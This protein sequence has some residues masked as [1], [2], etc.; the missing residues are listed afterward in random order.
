M[1]G[2]FMYSLKVVP[3]RTYEE[4]GAHT[5]IYINEINQLQIQRD[6]SIKILCF[7]CLGRGAVLKLRRCFEENRFPL[8]SG[9]KLC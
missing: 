6:Q 1:E 5:Y 7:L 8:F 4:E 3:A 2:K 9:E